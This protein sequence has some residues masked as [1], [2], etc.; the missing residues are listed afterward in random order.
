MHRLSTFDV[1]AAEATDASARVE[2]ARES[3]RGR[4]VESEGGVGVRM[5]KR[6]REEEVMDN[7][8][9][10]LDRPAL[11]RGCRRGVSAKLPLVRVGTVP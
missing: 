11:F 6:G 5:W 7:G 2:A 8:Q 3:M 9:S 4:G 10:T 1:E